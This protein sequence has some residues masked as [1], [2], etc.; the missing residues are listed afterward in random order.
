MAREKTHLRTLW[1]GTLLCLS[2]LLVFGCGGGGGGTG[3]S[4]NSSVSSGG[5]TIEF[6]DDTL[7]FNYSMNGPEPAAQI[8]TVWFGG[9]NYLE[10]GY[11]PGV[12]I[13]DWL[14]LRKV[15]PYDN[16]S[17]IE[18]EVSVS[19]PALSA[20]THQGTLRF[21]TSGIDRIPTGY[22]DLRVTCT[23]YNKL[24]LD[25]SELSFSHTNSSSSSPANQLVSIIGSGKAWSASA[26]QSWVVLSATSGVSPS[27]LEIGVNPSWLSVGN[28]PATVT[29][30]DNAS[31][32][33]ETLT[34]NLA[35]EPHRLFVGDNG[36]AF[37][38]FPTSRSALARTVKVAEN[39]SRTTSWT[40]SSNQSWLTV[41]PSGVTD[42]PLTLNAD[43][44]GLTADSIHYA[45][46]TVSSADTTIANDEV[47]EVGF[48]V[49]SADPAVTELSNTGTNIVADPVRPYAYVTYGGVSSG[50]ERTNVDVFNIYTG[51]KIASVVAGTNLGAMTISSDGKTLYVVDAGDQYAVDESIIPISLDALTVGNKWQAEDLSS[52]VRLEYTRFNGRGVILTSGRQVFDALDGTLAATIGYPISYYIVTAASQNND[53][54]YVMETGLSGYSF[55]LYRIVGSYS[56]INGTLSLTRTHWIETPATPRDMAVDAD[57][58]RIYLAGVGTFTFNGDNIVSGTE[59]TNPY[60]LTVETGPTNKLYVGIEYDPA[61]TVDAQSYTT[62]GEAEGSYTLSG[63]LTRGQLRISGDGLRMLT[64]SKS[65]YSYMSYLSF[66]A[67][68]P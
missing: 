58:S 27:S 17:P 16:N 25:K 10:Y 43:P 32:Q 33:S 18:L 3:S 54:F 31:G 50:S 39:A 23:V 22:K 49:A 28:H 37:S 59:L 63:E 57:G 60:G 13:P 20:G 8:I 19:A 42:G 55:E 1:M 5:D 46:V 11:P 26:D 6:S 21:V 62:N 68:E 51:V 40:A 9:A 48:Y 67:I 12:E 38:S 45:K 66:I 61:G 56:T 65:S 35:V 52:Y 64:L 53:S 30:R 41:T 4:S 44:S 47:I 2:I 15:D 7:N 29:V 24:G 36:V 34:L 14:H